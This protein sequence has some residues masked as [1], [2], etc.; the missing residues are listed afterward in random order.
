MRLIESVDP[1]IMQLVIVPFVV[2]GIGILIAVV[3]KKIY[4]GPITTMILTLSYNY[5]Y[6]T[7]FFP[8]S[9]LSFTMISSWCIIFPLLSLYLTWLI[10]RQ[11]QTIKSSFAIEARDLD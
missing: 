6:F 11:L 9:K 1:I 5:W 4:M 10:L 7:T 8:D 2:I 3:T